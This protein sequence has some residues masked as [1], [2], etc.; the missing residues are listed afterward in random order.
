MSFS[1][2]DVI[3][4]ALIGL[5]MIRCYLKGFVSELLT[6]AGIVLGLLAALYLHKNGGDF[7]RA[8]FWPELQTIPEIISFVFLF[9]V[10]F[11]VVKI[12]EKMLINIIDQVSLT[13]ADSYIGIVFGL[14][15]GVAVVSLILFL[16]K[17][18][19]L[20]DASAILSDSFFAR[21]LLPFI[22]GRESLSVSPEVM[23]V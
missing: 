1:F 10:V 22:T 17:V 11:I 7:L 20:F 18:Q 2:I 19:P 13:N 16:L 6:M 4:V 21:L 8:R 14:A 9:A 5:F 23:D 15:E 12:L 3:F